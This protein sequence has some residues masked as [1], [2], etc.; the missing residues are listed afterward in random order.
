MSALVKLFGY[1]G[2]F[3]L[4]KID[5][6][7]I[8]YPTGN[9][10]ENY[11]QAFLKI[12]GAKIGLNS[13][14]RSSAR[15]YF[16]KNLSIEENSK[17]GNSSNLYLYEKL[18]IGCNVEIGPNLLIYTGEHKYNDPSKP[19]TKQGSYHA[20]V[21]IKDDVYIGAR[22]TILKGSVINSRTIVA[23]GSVVSGTLESG[24]IYGG[25]PAKKIK[26]IVNHA[27]NKVEKA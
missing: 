1:C 4:N 27:N 22:V 13:Y 25:V 15:I 9:V 18:S 21:V 12:S 26:P 5:L 14:I 10:I 20:P 11:R 24:Y 16:I 19:L 8:H 3:L 23:A 7:F 6:R 17:I 2:F